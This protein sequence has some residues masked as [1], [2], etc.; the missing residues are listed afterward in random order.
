[1]FR[2]RQLKSKI[3]SLAPSSFNDIQQPAPKPATSSGQKSPAAAATIPLKPPQLSEYGGDQSDVPKRCV[4][5][6]SFK[7]V[8]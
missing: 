2:I 7:F 3:R 1:M 4:F 5:P 6:D 8:S